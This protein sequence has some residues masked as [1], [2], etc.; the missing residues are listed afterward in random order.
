MIESY[1]PNDKCIICKHRINK[2]CRAYQ[3]NIE[4]IEVKN[5]KR[6]KRND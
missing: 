3:T 5:C 2:Y 4:I 6:M 1:T